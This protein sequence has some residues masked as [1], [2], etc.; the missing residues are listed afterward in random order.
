MF[1]EHQLAARAR[2]RA[3]VDEVDRRNQPA[4]ERAR[5]D[6]T[7]QERQQKTPTPIP[8]GDGPTLHEDGKDEDH[9]RHDTQQ[10]LL[11]GLSPCV[12]QQAMDSDFKRLYAH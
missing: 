11:T 6:N 9:I 4:R 5:K 10:D 1:P 7:T 2:A 8:H 3:R 12:R